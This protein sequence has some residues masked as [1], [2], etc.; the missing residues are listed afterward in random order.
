MHFPNW[1]QCFQKLAKASAVNLDSFLNTLTL[2]LGAVTQGWVWQNM[3]TE[4]ERAD[5]GRSEAR[6]RR[7][8]EWWLTG[9][10]EEIF[11]PFCISPCQSP[12]HSIIYNFLRGTLHS[13]IITILQ[14][15]NS[16]LR[17]LG[18][19]VLSQASEVC[20][21]QDMNQ[22]WWILQPLGFPATCVAQVQ[23]IWNITALAIPLFH[24]LVEVK[25]KK[26]NK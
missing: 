7:R 17:K 20:Q 12:S 23:L 8:I 11:S 21:G 2:L 10:D 4:R 6:I 1:L 16:Q 26:E 3:K 14:M 13:Y 5:G 18:I 19:L 22:V 15:A 9:R 25:K 24:C